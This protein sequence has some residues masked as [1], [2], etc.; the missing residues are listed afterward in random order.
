[1]KKKKKKTGALRSDVYDKYIYILFF[2]RIK[3]C[4]FLRQKNDR[5]NSASCPCEDQQQQQ[6]ACA[7]GVRRGHTAWLQHGN[8]HSTQ[9]HT[10]QLE[11]IPA[12]KNQEY[13]QLNSTSSH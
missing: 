8:M 3:T 10:V 12:D 13:N 6:P 2:H 1:M 11:N 5:T 7:H 9:T 4:I